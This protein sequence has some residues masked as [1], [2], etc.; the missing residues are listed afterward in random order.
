MTL[1]I[2]SAHSLPPPLLSLLSAPYALG[3]L[4]MVSQPFTPSDRVLSGVRRP[5]YVEEVRNDE[6]GD[7]VSVENRPCSALAVSYQV[8]AEGPVIGL[9]RPPDR[10]QIQSEQTEKVRV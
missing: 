5:D 6:N 2:K 9:G 7:R 4:G 1:L 3:R 10:K 8:S